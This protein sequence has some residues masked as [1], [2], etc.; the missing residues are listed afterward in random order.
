[1]GVQTHSDPG[2]Y[3]WMSRDKTYGRMSQRVS[4][5]LGAAGYN[6]YIPLVQVGYNP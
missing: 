6:P 4:E 5:R 3:D 1:M 2:G